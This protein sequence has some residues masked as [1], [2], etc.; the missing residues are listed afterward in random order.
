MIETRKAKAMKSKARQGPM[1]IRRF[2]E[3]TR[4]CHTLTSMS[5]I[6]PI[7]QKQMLVILKA[8]QCHRPVLSRDV[9]ALRRLGVGEPLSFLCETEKE[10]ILLGEIVYAQH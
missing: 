4:G 7:I 9:S 8:L 10:G 3:A 1:C 2:H 5:V 6:K